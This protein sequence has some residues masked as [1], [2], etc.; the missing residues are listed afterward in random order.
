MD[1][2]YDYYCADKD[3]NDISTTTRCPNLP[4]HIN[5]SAHDI[6]CAFKRFLSGL[7]GGILGSLSLFDALVAIHSQLR[8]DP[9]LTTTRET[10][11]RARL[12]A[13]AI[14]TVNSQYQ[15]ELICA[16]FGLLCFIGRAAENAPRE[17]EDGR[18][19]PTADLMGYN[20]L[21]IIF[22][23]LLVNDLIHSYRMKV[24]DPG[25]GLVLLPMSP[26]KSRKEKQKEKQKEK[27]RNR[28]RGKQRSSKTRANDSCSP[29]SV[30]KTHIANGI[31]EMVIIH[32]REVVRQMRS[33]GT[34]KI[35][36]HENT[37]GRGNHKAKLISTASDLFP[38]RKPPDWD[39]TGPCY[40]D[41][42]ASPMARS[43]TATP[44]KLC[45]F[46][47]HKNLGVNAMSS[48]C[49]PATSR[50]H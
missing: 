46:L 3:G 1:A 11:L 31:A 39:D 26:P 22:G 9:E 41:R 19:L 37:A 5:C 38:L 36:R 25:A 48:N 34:L 40:H 18:P 24:A 42:S 2:L 28:Q 13:L 47:I 7:P 21:S 14:G 27:R 29:F 4:S 17:D 16:V 6:A 23:P 33:L 44:S 50:S 35:K 30:D 12:I 45:S 32:W 43:L 8:A 15:R 20:A 10:K 49:P